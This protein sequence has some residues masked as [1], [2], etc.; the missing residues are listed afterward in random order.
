MKTMP[1]RAPDDALDVL[2][3][4]H[5]AVGALAAMLA[6]LPAL[7]LFVNISLSDPA[8][9][10]TV[11]TQAAAALHFG[12]IALAVVAIAA[13][14]GI[15]ALLAGAGRC[16]QLRRRWAFCRAASIVGCLFLPFG[17]ILGATTL[18]ILLRP[19]VR[20]RFR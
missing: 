1:S 4:F 8:V 9:E 2:A 18:G 11:R 5:Y 15:G 3:Y 12:A 7:Y 16:L 14:L 19:E 17:T 10:P 20:A 6:L 13:G